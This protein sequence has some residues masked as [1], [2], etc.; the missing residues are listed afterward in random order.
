MRV[1]DVEQARECGRVASGRGGRAA[2]AGLRGGPAPA[3]GR[4]RGTGA[5]RRR[6]PAHLQPHPAITRGP[7]RRR[8]R[9]RHSAPTSAFPWEPLV[10]S[11][12]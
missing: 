2:R 8:L 11:S 1:R 12:A 6:A 5:A 4:R 9:L 10:S 3:R 7:P